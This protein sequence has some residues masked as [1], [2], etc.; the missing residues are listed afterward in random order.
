M[1]DKQFLKDYSSTLSLGT[2]IHVNH[3]GCSA[4]V[5]S[6]KRLYI[7]RVVGGVLGYC[8]HCRDHGFWRE[9]S[10]DGTLLRKWLM[11]KSTDHPVVHRD[12]YID[13]DVS[14]SDISSVAILNWLHKYYINPLKNHVD[15][16]YF[17]Q[18]GSSLYL[19]LYSGNNTQYGYQQRIFGVGPKYTTHYTKNIPDDVS[20]FFKPVKELAEERVLYI[21]EDYTSAYRIWRD[22]KHQSLALLKTSISNHTIGMIRKLQYKTICIWL[23]PDEPGI[24]ASKKIIE[25]LRFC[26]F[27]VDISQKTRIAVP[28][29]KVFTEEL[30]RRFCGL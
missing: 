17:R 5:D 18:E 27:D 19:P 29:P 6:K 25:R 30:L 9:L 11:G 26:L 14:R 3:E 20:W 8:H 28:E 23:D 16:K 2:Q 24:I 10:T 21:T 1:I 4:G 12:S 22:T 15:N 13:Y 7:K